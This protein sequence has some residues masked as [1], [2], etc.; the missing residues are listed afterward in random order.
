MNVAACALK[1]ERERR[2]THSLKEGVMHTNP[3][4]CEKDLF[5]SMQTSVTAITK[6]VLFL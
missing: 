5:Y 6:D 2:V 4:M 3:F 1:R